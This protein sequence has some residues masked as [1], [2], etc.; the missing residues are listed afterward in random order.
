MVSS[1]GLL[2]P[3]V[4]FSDYRCLVVLIKKNVLMV[5]SWLPVPVESQQRKIGFRGVRIYSG[6][7]L[8]SEKVSFKLKIE[9]LFT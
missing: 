4:C 3:A 5:K 1:S 8:P 9:L 2:T 6:Y 7:N